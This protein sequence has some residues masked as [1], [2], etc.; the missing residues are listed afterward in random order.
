M[1]KS[2]ND[3]NSNI[4]MDECEL[5]KW[6]ISHMWLFLMHVDNKCVVK[7][8]DVISRNVSRALKH[9]FLSK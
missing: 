4:P 9:M 6:D 3:E 5:L 8:P 1:P 2:V 7:G